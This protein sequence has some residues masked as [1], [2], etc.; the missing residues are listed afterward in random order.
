MKRTKAPWFKS[1]SLALAFF[2]FCTLTSAQQLYLDGEKAMKKID[3]LKV[4]QFTVSF[5]TS[6]FKSASTQSRSNFS[7]AKSALQIN[8]TGLTQELMQRITDE[9]YADFK[10]KAEAKGLPVSK[11]D[12]YENYPE[13]MKQY[14]P[15]TGNFTEDC[16]HYQAYSKLSSITVSANGEPCICNDQLPLMGIAAKESGS[17]PISISYLLGSGYL[18]A[19]AKVDENDF[20]GKIYNQTNVTFLPGL[21]VWWRS[22]ADIYLSKSKKAEIKINEH[23]GAVGPAGD[24]TVS[25][26]TDLGSYNRA[27]LTLAIDEQKYYSDAMQIL[28][29]A[30]SRIINAM[31]DAK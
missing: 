26:R 18:A 21:Q 24:L 13:S 27:T 5:M 29:E 23:I 2:L 30:N 8:T 20:L 28:K 1:G 22:G 6:E 17:Q 31:A 9:A 10:A 14:Y 15:S 7:G 19:K 4:A 12:G 11:F 3:D 25:D 16:D